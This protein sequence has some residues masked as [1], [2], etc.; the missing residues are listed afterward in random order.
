M[1]ALRQTS[2]R[3]KS[4]RLRRNGAEFD[5]PWA[6]RAACRACL[7]R[8]EV[9]A[10]GKRLRMVCLLA[11]LI[12]A[13]PVKPLTSSRLE[14]RAW[15]ALTQLAAA[16]APVGVEPARSWSMVQRRD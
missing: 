14:A 4:Q 10:S 3:I 7:C 6:V 1:P 5:C 11:S 12:V 9:E 13:R 15:T 8:A 2:H 16:E